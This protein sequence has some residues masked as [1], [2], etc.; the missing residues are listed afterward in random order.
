M[1]K[2]A[3]FRIKYQDSISAA[4][5]LSDSDNKPDPTRDSSVID[6]T[7]EDII[8]NL[9]FHV[10][11]LLELTPSLECPAED[12]VGISFAFP[13]SM[14]ELLDIPEPSR[15]FALMIKDIYPS[16]DMNLAKRLGLSNWQRRER[17]RIKLESAP[18]YRAT[19][20]SSSSSSSS[21][22]QHE[23]VHPASITRPSTAGLS[24]VYQ[25][26]VTDSLF[27]DVSLFDRELASPRIT[28]RAITTAPSVTSFA[29][30]NASDWGGGNRR[31]A[32]SLPQS[33]VFGTSFQCRICG[34]ILRDIRNKADWK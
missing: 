26:T 20:S 16:T 34:D 10:E 7:L 30:S 19:S 1:T 24:N 23:L 28:R 32:P 17:L 31:R 13:N 15:P 29:T 4:D 12:S 22:T 21:S 2:T 33:H 25:S 9:R 14:G 8:E 27:S 3:Q 5:S 6:D 11:N 18:I